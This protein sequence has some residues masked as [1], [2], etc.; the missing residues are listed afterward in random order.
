[1]PPMKRTAD[2]EAEPLAGTWSP[3]AVARH[4]GVSLATVRELR[5]T[6]QL[7]FCQIAGKVRVPQA[8]LKA[9]KYRPPRRRIARKVSGQRQP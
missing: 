6:G 2:P 5:S 7:D 3:M 8:A 4:W 9:C 1:M